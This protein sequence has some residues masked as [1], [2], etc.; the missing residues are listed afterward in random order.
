MTGQLRICPPIVKGN[1]ESR[2]PGNYVPSGTEPLEASLPS[3]APHSAGD[4]SLSNIRSLKNAMTAPD[5]R[6]LVKFCRMAIGRRSPRFQQNPTQEYPTGAAGLPS[7][8]ERFGSWDSVLPAATHR[9]NV[10]SADNDVFSIGCYSLYWMIVPSSA[11][12]GA[13]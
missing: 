11:Q 13:A 5:Y 10:A 6:S 3:H 8:G 12:C 1:K 4:A 2:D 9:R 7:T